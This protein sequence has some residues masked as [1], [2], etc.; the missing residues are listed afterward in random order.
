MVKSSALAWRERDMKSSVRESLLTWPLVAALA[1]IL[2]ILAV[3]QYRWSRQASDAAETR[4]HAN[5]Q[6]SLMNLRQ[7]L[8]REL[9]RACLEIMGSPG[10]SLSGK[11]LAR[12]LNRWESTSFP[13]LVKNVYIWQ[14]FEEDDERLL[15]L[16]P[17]QARLNPQPWP[18]ELRRLHSVLLAALNQGSPIF[19]GAQ[20]SGA[21]TVRGASP[22]PYIIAGI[23]QGIPILV[24]PAVPRSGTKWLLIELDPAILWSRLFPDLASEFFG[25]GSSSEYA[26]A[27]ETAG[28]DSRKLLFSSDAQFGHDND[29]PFDESLNL[30][31]PPNFNRNPRRMPSDMGHPPPGF[32]PG[33]SASP[34]APPNS[35]DAAFFGPIRFDPI[36][37][38]TNDSDWRIFAKHRQGSV[39]AAVDHLR[40][41][42]L[43]ISFGVL[44]VLAMSMAV[45]LLSTYRAHRLARLQIEFV[46]GVSH[47]LRTPVAAILSLSDNIASGV[48]SSPATIARHGTAIRTQARQLNHL[49]EQVLRFSS[50]KNLTLQLQPVSVAAVVENVLQNAA[51]QIAAAS[52]RVERDIP[53]DLL[54][55]QA[56]PFILSQC[57]Q[58][59]ISNA[60]KYGGDAKWV[61]IRACS[62]PVQN[63]SSEVRITV[64][65]KGIG[66]SREDMKQVFQPFYRSASVSES[67]IHGTGLGLALAT[68]YAE[69]MGGSLTVKS[70]LG[71]GTSFTVHLPAAGPG[72]TT[73]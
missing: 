5:L 28:T 40:T 44:L 43:A 12:R 60:V 69:S 11:D 15:V 9:A 46:A 18:P 59:L 14:F 45:I 25:D 29:G 19:A 68:R 3:L 7:A 70:E 63:G 4:M 58:N 21:N 61:G 64:E 50:L 41:R 35:P 38:G 2:I 49:I 72:L 42:N 54:D 10:D 30:F 24:V 26:V 48:S 16:Q 20:D 52:V 65:D 56:D 55:P 23:D 1:G 73:T 13:G 6:N 31:G 51:E 36:Y 57:L 66:I 17:N 67:S 62:V 53:G 32:R 8:S 39:A 22:N 33:P 47:E 34:G 71:V 27:V 37:A